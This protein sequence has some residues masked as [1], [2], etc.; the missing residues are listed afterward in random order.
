MNKV[1]KFVTIGM[2]AGLLAALAFVPAAA[3]DQTCCQ[4]GTI[5]EG[6]FGGDIAS[7]NPILASDASSAQIAGMLNIGFIGVDPNTAVLAENQ[8]GALVK[9]WDISADGTVYTFHLRNDLTWTDGTP[10]TSADVMYTWKAI[11]AAA[12][13]TVNSSLSFVIDSSGKT[14]ILDVQAP[15]D[16]TVVVKFANAQC[17]ALGFASALVP[18]PVQAMPADVTQLNDAPYNLDPTVTSG[19]FKFGAMRPSE[20]VSLVGSSDYKDATAGVVK[21]AGF[22]YKNVPDANVNVEQFLAGETN[23]ID[24]PAVARRADIRASGAQVYSYPGNSW[25]YL[26]L[27]L[28]DPSNP[29]NGLDDKG[30]VI[31]QGHHPI[32]GDVRVRQ[33]ISHAIDVDAIVKAALF[34]EGTRMTSNLIPASWAY[35]SSL[36]PISYDPKLAGQM[37]DQAGWIDDDNNPATPRVAKGAMY[38][39]DGTKFEF[40]LYTNQGNTRREAEGTLIQDQLAQI[41]VKV[42]F[43]TIDFNT[44]IDI[45]QSETFDAYIL[46]WLNGYPDDPDQTQL[47]TPQND[48]VGSGSNF[49]SY[50]SQQFTDLTNQANS[51]AGCKTADRAP[52]YSKIQKLMQQDVPYVWLLAT[53]G[54]YAASPNVQGFDP[55]PSNFLWNIDAWSV[56]TP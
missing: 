4:G 22:I 17:T 37:L 40:T 27:N 12:A 8:P 30:N 20:Q 19:P 52:I 55:R 31:D 18:V 11:Q 29:Q 46:G 13:G 10:I 35:D 24:G 38:A 25:D 34:G 1:V 9:T 3:Q 6:N 47:F 2:S 39:P 23:F 50:N 15:D 16:Y 44:L 56:A 14:G 28:A 33:A 48:V 41:G 42:D 43:Q 5:I 51:V 32:F 54:M 36:P 45:M 53:N 21:P 7:M 49:T 26:A